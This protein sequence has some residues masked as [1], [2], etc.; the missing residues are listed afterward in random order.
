MIEAACVRRNKGNRI[1]ALRVSISERRTKQD[2]E[3]PGTMYGRAK[4]SQKCTSRVTAILSAIFY[5][6]THGSQRGA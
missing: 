5:F 4:S 1:E 3:E 6:V 2:A